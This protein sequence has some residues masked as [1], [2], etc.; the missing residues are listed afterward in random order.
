MLDT[1]GP[2]Y[3]NF[4]NQPMAIWSSRDFSH[5]QPKAFHFVLHIYNRYNIY[6]REWKKEQTSRILG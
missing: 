2:H 4:F 5:L 1:A 6:N 3:L